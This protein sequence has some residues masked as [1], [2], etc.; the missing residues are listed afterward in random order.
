VAEKNGPVPEVPSENPVA[1]RK[2]LRVQF[3]EVDAVEPQTSATKKLADNQI[4]FC[5]RI[6]HMDEDL[7]TLGRDMILGFTA[8]SS[9]VDT[10]MGLPPM[11]RREDSSHAIEETSERI[12]ETAKRKAQQ[13]VDSPDVELTPDVVKDL[14]KA[15]VKAA[16]DAQRETD[17]NKK[18]EADLAK[19]EADRIQKEKDDRDRA[20][21]RR[22]FRRNIIIAVI[23]GLFAF[24]GVA[25]GV[26]MEGHSQGRTEGF[27]EGS[28]KAPAVLVPVPPSALANV[29]MMPT[30]MF[31]ASSAV[32]PMAPAAVVPKHP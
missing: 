6:D 22:D 5:D 9:K 10:L 19:I 23:G 4:L 11:R 32:T 21:E 7:V 25:Y 3:Q 30:P 13:I 2:P 17:K 15:E 16:L 8:L 14:M 1:V 20:K 26:Y 28:T 24:A 27:A 31:S 18:M 29:Q 12:G